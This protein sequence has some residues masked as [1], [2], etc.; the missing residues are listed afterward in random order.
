M[1]QTETQ[2]IAV[3][4]SRLSPCATVIKQLGYK[5][6]IIGVEGILLP[7]KSQS[8][9]INPFTQD[10]KNVLIQSLHNKV[11]ED[12][13]LWII[14]LLS[15]GILVSLIT[16]ESDKNNGNVSTVTHGFVFD[17]PDML[18]QVLE[19]KLGVEVCQ[20]FE[21]TYS[22][23]PMQFAQQAAKHYHFHRQ[24]ILLIHEDP[25]IILEARKQKMGGFL[26]D[27]L[28]RGLRL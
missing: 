9:T 12:V 20:H 4:D 26:V 18:K 17:G 10:A 1:G 21:I 7:Q 8:Y 2:F 15:K 11:S 24:E 16:N 28:S 27:D 23:N 3:P 14:A 13:I 6:V 19:E 5:L 25:N 22:S